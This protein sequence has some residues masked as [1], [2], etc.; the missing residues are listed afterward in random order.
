MQQTETKEQH[1]WAHV[2]NVCCRTASTVSN[3]LRTQSAFVVVPADEAQD[4]LV[5]FEYISHGCIIP[6]HCIPL[7]QR[8]VSH[9]YI[10]GKFNRPR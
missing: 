5:P 4:F 3:P 2:Q 1:T 7:K 10:A 6:A 8:I 9:M